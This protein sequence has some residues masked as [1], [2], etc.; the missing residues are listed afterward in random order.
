VSIK[1]L[2]NVVTNSDAKFIAVFRRMCGSC[3]R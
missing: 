1:F 3:A 2:A